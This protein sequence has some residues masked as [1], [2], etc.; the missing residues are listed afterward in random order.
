MAGQRHPTFVT[1]RAQGAPTLARANAAPRPDGYDNR[2]PILRFQ[3]VIG[4]AGLDRAMDLLVC[5]TPDIVDVDQCGSDFSRE[6]Y[7][8]QGF[9]DQERFTP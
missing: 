9:P 1:N 4:S 7:V 5:P 2:S 3:E 6:S 8:H